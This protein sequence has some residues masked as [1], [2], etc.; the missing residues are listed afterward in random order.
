MTQQDVSLLLC[1]LGCTCLASAWIG[2]AMGDAARDVRLALGTGSLL[3]TFG[4]W[5]LV[6]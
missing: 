4:G 6:A 5:I 1:F 3:L 2:R